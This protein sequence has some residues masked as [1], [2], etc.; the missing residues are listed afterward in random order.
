[1]LPEVDCFPMP[2]IWEQLDEDTYGMFSKFFNSRE[3]K[4][5]IDRYIGHGDIF[6]KIFILV[7]NTYIITPD[8]ERYLETRLNDS[9]EKALAEWLLTALGCM[10]HG[11][12]PGLD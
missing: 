6:Y 9:A 4:D 12:Y 1:M 7:G 3:L 8:N 10:K 11:M 2:R 5:L